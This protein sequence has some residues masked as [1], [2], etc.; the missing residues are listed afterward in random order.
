M[1]ITST[2]LFS[3]FE[4]AKVCGAYH[5]TVINWINKGM[6]KARVT[7]GGHRR[8][9]LPDLLDFMKRFEMP[10]PADLTSRPKRVL[11]VEDDPA[12]QRMIKRTLA[13]LPSLDVQA[14]DNGLEALIAIG[15][16]APDLIVLDI[17][18]PRVDGLE[19]CSVLRGSEQTRPIKIVAVTGEDLT[20]ERRTLLQSHVDAFF[21]KPLPTEHLK[22]KVL[23]LLELEEAASSS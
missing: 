8:V 9:A 3:T 14:C 19:V 21:R 20:Q 5:T 18:I 2:R 22:S 23:E 7:P 13:A 16:E 15:K 4:T 6:L 10:I 17:N 11:V 12:V 1:I